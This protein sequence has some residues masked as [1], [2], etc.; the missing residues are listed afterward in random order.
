MWIDTQG[1]IRRVSSTVDVRQ[2]TGT[3]HT[4]ETFEY[5]NFGTDVS[6]SAP[7]AREVLDFSQFLGQL[8]SSLG[9]A[10]GSGVPNI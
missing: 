4:T 3:A 2:G 1:R 7:P 9:G 8:G 5:S 6:V 10:R